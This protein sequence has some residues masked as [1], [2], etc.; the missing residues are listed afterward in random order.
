[1]RYTDIAI[2]GGGLAGTALGAL[3]GLAEQGRRA[4]RPRPPLRSTDAPRS[5]LV[6]IIF[7]V[8]IVAVIVRL[9]GGVVRRMA[10]IVP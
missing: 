6:V 3:P 9:T 4:T 7:V 5:F 2:I 1:M 8:I 10:L